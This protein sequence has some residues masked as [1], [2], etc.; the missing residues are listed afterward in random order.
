MK[1]K[2]LKDFLNGLKEEDLEHDIYFDTEGKS[3]NYHMAKIKG[4]YLED[5]PKPNLTF[6]EE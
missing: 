5:F 4:V 3:Y 6:Y 1:I 2:Q